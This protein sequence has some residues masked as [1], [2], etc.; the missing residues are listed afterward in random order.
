MARRRRYK[1]RKFVPDVVYGKVAVTRF[2]NLVMRRGKASVAEKLVYIALRG[3]AEALDQDASVSFATAIDNVTPAVEVRPKRMGGAT[4]QVPVEVS[5]G[6]GRS[7]G[8]RAI[9]RGAASSRKNSSYDVCLK[10]EIINA[11]NNTGVAVK[12]RDEKHKMAEANKAYS[13]IRF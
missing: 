4:Y 9:I 2:I 11:Y 8:K 7:L 6:R 3:V 12:A 5:L 13:H 10:R 1:S